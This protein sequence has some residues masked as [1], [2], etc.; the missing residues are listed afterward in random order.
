MSIEADTK[1]KKCRGRVREVDQRWARGCRRG[2]EEKRQRDGQE[3]IGEGRHSE[4]GY[5][6]HGKGKERKGP[7][8]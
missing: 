8:G 1:R 2:E 5:G 6:C 4:E 3:R 7:R